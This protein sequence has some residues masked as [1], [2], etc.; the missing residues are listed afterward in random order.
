VKATVVWILASAVAAF[1]GVAL[2]ATVGLTS[3][4]T[5]SGNVAVVACDDAFTQGYATSGGKVTTV[6]V[7]GIADPACEGGSLSLRLTDAAGDSIASAGP[8]TVPADGDTVD[9]LLVLAAS[10][11][12][13][14][15]QV[16]GIVI[17]VVGP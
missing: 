15:G 13:N 12:P 2:A 14:A 16:G 3:S 4:R 1:V 17:S 11:Q 10:P 5:G 9:D 8:Q 7:G 6:T